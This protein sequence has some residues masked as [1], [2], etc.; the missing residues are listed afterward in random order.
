LIKKKKKVDRVFDNL[1]KRELMNE[2]K[3]ERER[4]IKS[5]FGHNV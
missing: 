1:V 3:K 5:G 4:G 2:R